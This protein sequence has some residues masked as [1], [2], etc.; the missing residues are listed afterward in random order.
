[1]NRAPFQVLIIPYYLK[2]DLGVGYGIF[3]RTKES[4][5]FW[6]AIAG[7]GEDQETPLEAAKR[8]TFE[9]AG[10]PPSALFMELSSMTTIPV[11]NVQG[12]LWG[13]DI[14]VIPEYSFGVFVPDKK[15][16]LSREHEELRWVDYEAAFRLLKWDSNRSALWEL[17]YRLS[18]QYKFTKNIGKK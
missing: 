15:I 5:G 10:I 18:R 17:N 4:G 11:V 6:Q 2:K 8:E 14:L 12:F 7:G 1:M 9:E 16:T 13:E 3:R